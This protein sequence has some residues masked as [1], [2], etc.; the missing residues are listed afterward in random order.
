[1]KTTLVLV[2]LLMLVSCG[3]DS[4][5]SSSKSKTD[6]YKMSQNNPQVSQLYTSLEASGLDFYDDGDKISLECRNVYNISNIQRITSLV[7]LRSIIAQNP[8]AVVEFAYGELYSFQM[9]MLLT[10]AINRLQAFGYYSNSCPTSVL[11]EVNY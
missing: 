4:K 7:N 1:M 10:G 9:D 6:P 3:K 8:Q 5:S 2:T 11:S